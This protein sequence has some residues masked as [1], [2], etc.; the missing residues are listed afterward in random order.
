MTCGR[1]PSSISLHLLLLSAQEQKALSTA[2]PAIIIDDDLSDPKPDS[3]DALCCR[4]HCRHVVHPTRSVPIAHF[5]RPACRESRVA[6][7]TSHIPY[8]D[9]WGILICSIMHCK[10][11]FA[12]HSSLAPMD[13]VANKLV[14]Q[15]L[16]A[17]RSTS[18]Q[19][20]LFAIGQHRPMCQQALLL[21]SM[22]Q[23]DQYRETLS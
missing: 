11:S 10:G 2:R 14:C 4:T 3:I 15:S 12:M 13:P 1:R 7:R 19:T 8:R 22:P 21:P 18:P 16:G 5:Q 23:L 6:N 20:T 17:N 9:V